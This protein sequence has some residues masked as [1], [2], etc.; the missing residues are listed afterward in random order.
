MTLAQLRAFPVTIDNK[1][2]D[3]CRGYHESLLR[4]Y[5][6]L[7]K[8]REWLLLGTPPSVV[9]EMIG[10]AYDE[11][12]GESSVR[13]WLQLQKDTSGIERDMGLRQ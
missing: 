13:T 4:S 8:A 2:G 6:V 3:T 5:Q 9:L 12:D 10:D 11:G 7:Q 1:P